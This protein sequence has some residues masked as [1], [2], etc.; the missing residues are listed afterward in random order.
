MSIT[1]KLKYG[2]NGEQQQWLA[3]NVG[4]RLFYLHD[5][6]GGEGWIARYVWSE[7]VVHKYWSLTLEDER[8]ASFFLIK[9]PQ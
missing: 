9:F 4:P 6:V 8:Y 3:K 7:G 5:K 2:L 1:I